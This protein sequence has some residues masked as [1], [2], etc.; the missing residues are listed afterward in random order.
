MAVKENQQ[1]T[2]DPILPKQFYCFFVACERGVLCY[3]CKQ[4]QTGL[5][6]YQAVVPRN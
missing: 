6:S 3:T 4:L 1:E 2:V 5:T